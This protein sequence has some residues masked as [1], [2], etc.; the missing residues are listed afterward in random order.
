MAR[1]KILLDQ[2]KSPSGSE[3]EKDRRV[4]FRGF[5]LLLWLAGIAALLP[6]WF[7]FAGK[8]ST[9]ELM[10]GLVA[11]VEAASLSEVA[12]STGFAPFY[13][14]P[15]WLIHLGKVPGEVLADCAIL[16][17]ILAGRIVH[18]R[19]ERGFFKAVSFHSG[20]AGARSAARRALAITVGTLSPNTCVVDI[21]PH[22]DFALLHQIRETPAPEFLRIVSEE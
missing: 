4:I 16:L 7:V 1:R 6:L 18:H 2:R 10:A 22:H 13:P 12:R 21:E 8:F 11:A 9:A 20:G 17:V 3:L 15:R 5:S 14:R 19:Q